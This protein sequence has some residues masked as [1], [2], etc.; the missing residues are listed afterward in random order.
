MIRE[1]SILLLR[2][3]KEVIVLEVYNDS[4]KVHLIQK[5]WSIE[6]DESF[7]ISGKDIEV[8]IANT[9]FR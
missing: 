5:K 3:G 2:C 6:V 9:K 4:Y 1:G 7:V 8:C